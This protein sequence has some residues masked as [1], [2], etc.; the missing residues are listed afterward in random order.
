LK[1]K[2]AELFVYTGLHLELWLGPFLDAV[3]RPEVMPGGPRALDMSA[4]IAILDAPEEIATRAE[5]EMYF[6]PE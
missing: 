4:G 2:R 3:G 1:T 5:G 6:E